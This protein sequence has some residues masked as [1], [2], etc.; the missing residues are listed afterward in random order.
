MNELPGGREDADFSSALF[1][2]LSGGKSNRPVADDL[3]L[4]SRL[5]RAP[6]DFSPLY[7]SD[8]MSWCFASVAAAAY[9]GCEQHVCDCA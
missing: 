8:W 7:A 6:G 4:C 3:M 5:F 2:F 1:L 9:S